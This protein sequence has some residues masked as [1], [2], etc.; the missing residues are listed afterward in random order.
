MPLPNFSTVM[1]MV[2]CLESISAEY[3]EIEGVLGNDHQ[4]QIQTLG[5]QYFP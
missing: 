1:H 3:A 5:T 4:G 2:R